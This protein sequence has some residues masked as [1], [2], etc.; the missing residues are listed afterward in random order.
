MG[1]ELVKS[2]CG[3]CS[4]RCPI[5]VEVVDGKAEYIQGNPDAPGIMGSL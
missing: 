5:E 3:M 4:V 1:K 2:I